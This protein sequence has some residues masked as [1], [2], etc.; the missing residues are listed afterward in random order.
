MASTLLMAPGGAML[1]ATL[2]PMLDPDEIAP[3]RIRGLRRVEYDRLVDLGVFEDEKIE[4]LCGVLVEM[5]PQGTRHAAVGRRLTE[6]LMFAL[7]RRAMVGC[8]FPFA[9]GEFSE[10]EPDIAVTPRS[11][12]ESE[13]PARAFLIIE[14]A[15]SSIR[16]DRGLKA[17]I[18]AAAGVPEY[19]VVDLN[20]N[21]IEI[22]TGP[23]PD[24]Y[25]ERR[26][27]ARGERLRLVEFPD[28]ELAVDEILP[29]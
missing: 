25:A 9:A 29:K 27:A 1:R 13:H 16:K 2:E 17:A 11:D 6:L 19:W 23:G 15:E 24:G 8:Q 14:V 4:L 3:E 18:Y 7:G 12:D 26:R 20:Q 21:H 22:F 10:P 5:S 28:V